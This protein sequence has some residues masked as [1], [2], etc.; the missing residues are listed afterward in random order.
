M[1]NDDKMIYEVPSLEL[2]ERSVVLM[3]QQMPADATPVF[4]PDDDPD[5]EG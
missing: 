4:D 3:G 1:K 5:F 2:I